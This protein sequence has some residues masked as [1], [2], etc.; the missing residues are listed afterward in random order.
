MSEVHATMTGLET[1]FEEE[2]SSVPGWHSEL[3]DL[4]HEKM[5]AQTKDTKQDQAVEESMVLGE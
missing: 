2:L 5:P 1:C 3:K 4:E